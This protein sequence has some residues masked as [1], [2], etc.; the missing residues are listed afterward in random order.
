MV[1][2]VLAARL[3]RDRVDQEVVQVTAADVLDDREYVRAMQDAH[4]T[5][6]PDA[7]VQVRRRQRAAIAAAAAER[8]AE[9]EGTAGDL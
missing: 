6:G 4:R 3:D 5:G 2:K 8:A 1:E 9:G 7:V